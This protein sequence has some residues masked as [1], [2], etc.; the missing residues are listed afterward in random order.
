MKPGT[1]P[2]KFPSKT[3]RVK[4]QGVAKGAACNSCA[5]AGPGP[6]SLR[7]PPLGLS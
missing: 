6:V 5:G 4:R 3:L 2:R 7:I 1:H